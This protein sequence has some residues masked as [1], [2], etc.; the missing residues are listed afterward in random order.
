MKRLFPI[1]VFA[2]LLGW[3]VGLTV[4]A[5][6]INFVDRVKKDAAKA[7]GTIVD[8]S[9]SEISYKTGTG[10]SKKI[11]AGDVIDVFYEVRPKLRPDY[12]SAS[13][14]ER[15]VEKANNDDARKKA[16][17]EAI[18]EYQSLLPQLAEEEK[19]FPQRHAQYKIAY[20]T[21]KLADVDPTQADAAM[22]AVKQFLKEQS[23]GWQTLPAAKLLARLQMDRSDFDGAQKTYEDLSK[24]DK[25]SDEV[26]QECN[27]LSAQAM[28]RAKKYKEA[29][30]RLED[31]LKSVAAD[32]PEAARVRVFL[33]ECRAATGELPAAIKDL[34]DVIGKNPDAGLRALAYNTLG[35]CYVA[36]KQPKDALWQYLMVDVIYNQDKQEHLKAMQAL[37]K[38]FEEIK[39]ENR[40]KQYKEK[41]LKGR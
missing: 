20:L 14:K 32:S 38:V 9:P 2:I 10:G 37:V 40:S 16:I 34:E 35:D 21:A 31:A 6:D 15:A 26:K 19:K 11:A 25:V 18:K 30:S 22:D 29:R 41:L 17:A 4:R 23:G 27:L 8:E 39:D 13:N 28:T 33:A 5:D 36:A 7:T 1:G 3:I 24:M 12:R